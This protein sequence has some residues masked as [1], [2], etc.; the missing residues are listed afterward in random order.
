[1]SLHRPAA[2]QVRGEAEAQNKE[3]FARRTPPC[4]LGSGRSA[5]VV[6][7]VADGFALCERYS[8]QPNRVIA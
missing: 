3:V 5:A 4:R 8:F 7:S 2:T 6:L 1:M